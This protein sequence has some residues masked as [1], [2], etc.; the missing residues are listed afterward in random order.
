MLRGALASVAG[1]CVCGNPWG[2]RPLRDGAPEVLAD[3]LEDGGL[4]LRRGEENGAFT[5]M[6][7][8]LGYL[9]SAGSDLHG[10]NKPHIALGM[11]VS[12]DF[13]GPLLEA[14]ILL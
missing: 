1:G 5:R 9:L 2:G 6:A 10:A 12:E 8:K 14:L 11:E 13:I 4:R 7:T 3:G